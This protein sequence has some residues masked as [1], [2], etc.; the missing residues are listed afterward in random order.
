M[1][2]SAS[3]GAASLLAAAV[4][5]GPALA[6]GMPSRGR[7]AD[8]PAPRACVTSGNVAFTTDY[9]FRGISQSNQNA[10]VQG[11]VDLT[12][13]KFYLGVWGSSI[14]FGTDGTTEIDIYG[15]Y[16]TTIGRF[17]L[18]VGFIYYGYPGQPSFND[19]P[20]FEVKAGATTEVWKG[21]TVGATVFYS[22]EYTFNTGAVTTLEGSFSQELPKVG[23]F[24]P[25]FSV[26]VGRSFFHDADELSYTYWNAGV[27]FAF[28]ERWS[29]DLRYWDSDNE[30]FTTP[31]SLSDERFI[32]T[33]K[34][35]F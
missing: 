8:A 3:L 10:A 9:V 15:G 16:K 19:A 23:M 11:G 26:L 22:P 6:D 18:D 24:A 34:Y 25:T 20:Y 5:A 32:A 31:T 12:C 33:V 13:G 17:A 28:L 7:I 14:D 35:T 29:L 1:I 27:T 4:F 30:L 2:K 21:G